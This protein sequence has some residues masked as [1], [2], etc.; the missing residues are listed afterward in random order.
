LH[1][2]YDPDVA[3]LDV[4]QFDVVRPD[5]DPDDRTELVAQLGVAG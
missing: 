2:R 5:V 1:V 3:Q 4:T